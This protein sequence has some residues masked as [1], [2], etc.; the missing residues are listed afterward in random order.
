MVEAVADRR[1]AAGDA[2]DLDRHDLLAEQGDDAV[3]R[4]H[5]AQAIADS[6]QRID[7]GQGKSRDDA[8]DRLG[9]DVR[10]RAARPARSP[11]NRRRRAPRAGPA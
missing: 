6:P 9:E 3:Q 1:R 8:L 4:P 10:S 2:V 5:P 7:L 11:R